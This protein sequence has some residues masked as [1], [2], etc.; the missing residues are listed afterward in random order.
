MAITFQKQLKKQR[1]LFIVFIG[2]VAI[3]ILIIF[4]GNII[5][6]QPSPEEL[7]VRFKK[8]KIDYGIFENPLFKELNSI[9]RIPSFEGER[10]RENP[11]IPSF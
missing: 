9:E 7:L 11:F 8:I 1:T 4:G 3:T 2:L 6:R 10:G 5:R